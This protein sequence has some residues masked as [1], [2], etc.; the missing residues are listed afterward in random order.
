MVETI[1]TETFQQILKG[2]KELYLDQGA[3]Q[4]TKE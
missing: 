1:N 3:I 2:A 4:I